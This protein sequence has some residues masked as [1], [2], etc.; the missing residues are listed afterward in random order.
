MHVEFRRVVEERQHLATKAQRAELLEPIDRQ[1]A[2]LLRSM[3]NDL[4]IPLSTIRA[5][6]SDRE[7]SGYDAMRAERLG[8]W[9]T[10]PIA[11]TALWPTC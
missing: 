8:S 3:P 10:R 4:H 5:V 7:D 11:W 9:A 1:R 2:A 6:P